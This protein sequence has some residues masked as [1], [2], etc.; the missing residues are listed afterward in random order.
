V[1]EEGLQ[2][3]DRVIV[4]GQNQVAH[5]DLVQVVRTREPASGEGGS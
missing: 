5:G 3:G 4:V 2:A 1:V